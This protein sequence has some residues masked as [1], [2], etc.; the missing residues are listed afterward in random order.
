MSQR[1]GKRS[2]ADSSN[3][4]GDVNQSSLSAS[5]SSGTTKAQFCS[6]MCTSIAMTHW[7]NM[8]KSIQDGL[9]TT[10]CNRHYVSNNATY[11]DTTISIENGD[12]DIDTDI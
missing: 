5:S 12:E 10:Y 4:S 1:R 11:V 6:I 3:V 7:I 8:H 9:E 2:N